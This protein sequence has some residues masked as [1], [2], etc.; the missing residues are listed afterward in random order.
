LAALHLGLSWLVWGVFVRT[1]AVWHI[2]W[3]V[4][5]LTHIWGYQNFDTHDDSKNN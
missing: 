1:V 3:S 4:N 2:T 5:S